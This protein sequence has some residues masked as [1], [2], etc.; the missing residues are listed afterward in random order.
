MELRFF[1]L[2][3]SPEYIYLLLEGAVVSFT[4]TAVAGLVDTIYWSG[5][6]D[7]GSI[8][9]LS[10]GIHASHHLGR[11]KTKQRFVNQS[12]FTTKSDR[13]TNAYGEV[14][15]GYLNNSDENTEVS[16]VTK[17]KFSDKLTEVSAT[18]QYKKKF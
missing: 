16:F 3:R 6:E 5:N 12:S 15:F 4:I 13:K 2:Y 10:F 8:P 18:L 11:T 17:G 14:S 7:R 9:F 1:E